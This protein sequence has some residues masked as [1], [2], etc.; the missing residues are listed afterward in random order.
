MIK[1]YREKLSQ[2]SK[3]R[4][5]DYIAMVS[6]NLFTLQDHYMGRIQEKYGNE[7]AEEFDE[8]VY[9]RASEIAV[10]RFKKFFNLGDDMETLALYFEISPYAIHVGGI[11]FPVR[12]DKKLVR[13]V[14]ACASQIK[15]LKKGKIEFPCKTATLAVNA[16]V[17][18]TV[19][20]KIRI[21]SVMAPPDPHPDDLYCEIVFEMED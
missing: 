5:I 17:A 8:H 18:K 16:K 1:S 11:D 7:V 9:G 6:E 12:T 14:P 13:R 19:N 3:E 10:Y 21:T 4:L 15:R 2:L 20:P